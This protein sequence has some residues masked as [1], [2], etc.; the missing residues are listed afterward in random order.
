MVD[1]EWNFGQANREF[2][3]GFSYNPNIIYIGKENETY[4]ATCISVGLLI[5]KLNIY[6]QW[7]KTE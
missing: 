7:E 6:T 3:I 4:I 1:I 2:L 5:I